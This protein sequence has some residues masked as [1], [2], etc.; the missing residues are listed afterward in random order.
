M[1]M[2]PTTPRYISTGNQVVAQLGFQLFIWSFPAGMNTNYRIMKIVGALPG[3]YANCNTLPA[4]LR[5]PQTVMEVIG[6]VTGHTPYFWESNPPVGP[7]YYT[8]RNSEGGYITAFDCANNRFALYLKWT[9]E[10]ETAPTNYYITAKFH[11]NTY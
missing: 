4:G 8:A 6:P 1:T 9:Q 5:W 11:Y 3:G 2:T 7:I 10:L